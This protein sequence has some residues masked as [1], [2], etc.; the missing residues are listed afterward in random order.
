MKKEDISKVIGNI[1]ASH[2][3]EAE[4]YTACA[5]IK[6]RSKAFVVKV[7]VA[8][9]LATC[10]IAGA[11]VY[12]TP[13]VH[14]MPPSISFEDGTKVDIAEDVPF[15][16]IPETAPKSIRTEKDYIKIGMTH[17]EV[18]AALGFD[19][20]KYDGITTDR[21]TYDTL[22]NNDGTIGRISLWWPRFFEIS[23]DKGITLSISILN[24]GADYGYI[25]AFMQGIDAAGGKKLE[26]TVKIESL[27]VDAVVY[28]DRSS[29]DK[30]AITFI[31][32]NVYYEFAGY[33]CTQS[34]ILSIIEQLK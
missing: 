19:I 7:L 10:L 1:S 25:D 14:K 15:K 18:E 29:E 8:A 33:N 16:D 6:I 27:G 2:I 28:T 30:L 17:A 9:C 26:N 24:K 32:D 34:E 5:K 4:N 3:T 21:L 23:E 22:L 31:Y 13:E 11:V 12:A 20:L